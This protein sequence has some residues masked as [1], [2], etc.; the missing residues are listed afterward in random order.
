MKKIYLLFLLILLIPK[1]LTGQVQ[2]DANF[3]SGNINT[4]TTTDSVT[5]NVTTKEDIG[6]RWFYFRIRNVKNR[7]VKVNITN[8][9]VKRGVYSYNNKDYIRFTDTESPA[10]HVFQKTYEQD[11]VY[12]S[13][14]TPYN[15]SYLQQRLATWNQSPFVR[16]DTI[17]YTLRNLPLQ[18]MRITDSSVP[19]SAK[20]R[21]WI[22]ARTHPGET[23]SSWHLDG[24]VEKLLQDDE[25]M[26]EY[27]KKM[28]FHTIPFTN[29][30][31]VYYGRS[32]TNFDGVDVESNWNRADSQ[33]CRE[34]ALLKARMGWINDQKVLSVFSNLHSQATNSC[35]FWIHTA[36]STSVR[37]YRRQLQFANLNTS[38]NPYFVPGNYSFSSLSSTFPEGWLWNNHGENV[39]AL[40][41]ET[42][43][44]WYPQ[45]DL[46][47][48]E[49]L[50][51]LG[52]H[53]LFAIAEFLEI[54]HPKYI[55]LDNKDFV[56]NWRIDSTGNE[57]FSNDYSA[58]YQSDNFGSINYE[59]EQIQPGNYEVWGWWPSNSA[60]ANNTRM[61]VNSGSETITKFV[62][63]RFNGAKWNLLGRVNLR[64][65]GRI[66]IAVSDSATG[67]IVADAFKIIYK[68][69]PTYAEAF[70][71]EKNFVMYQNYPNPFN[72]T[73]TIKFYLKESGKVKL[74]VYNTLGELI[75]NLV[76]EELGEG[77][78]QIIFDTNNLNI[79][80]GVYYLQLITNK[81][82]ETKGMLLLK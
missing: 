28:I 11:T 40:T 37:F 6:G 12:V 30:D 23:P 68:G 60:N 49:N 20:L 51:W 53:Q 65:T 72:G 24:L 63:Q 43:Y 78:H 71:E 7:F 67:R 82:S 36:S 44:D 17:G 25:V 77:N 45:G 47:T 56:S 13:Y 21:V 52:E 27:R 9:D 62:D 58:A 32:R 79:A 46:V 57:F 42:P 29:P 73:T 19:D 15:F 31:G 41:Y 76:D 75:V 54:S 80:S 35:T 14:Y 26:A 2:F 1:G 61:T 55:L 5:F 66:N 50:K 48:N 22:H 39:L 38:N 59:T 70:T 4:V 10:N 8:T 33:T 81:H 16:I 74:R 18:E 3:E 34:V 64:N 69:A